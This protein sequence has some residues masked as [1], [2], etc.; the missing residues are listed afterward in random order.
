MEVLRIKPLHGADGYLRWKESVLLGLNIAGVAHVLSDDPPP[1]S[2]ARGVDG[3][4]A[5]LAS[6]AAAKKQWARD[7]AVC[8]GHI[9]RALS[10]RLLPV[11][12]RHGTGRA[13]W[14]AVARTYEPNP[15]SWALKLEEL[16]FGKDETLLERL[17]RAEALV[18]AGSR[19]RPGP[20][21]DEC[22]LARMVALKLQGELAS[23]AI[24]KGDRLTMD[25]VWRECQANEACT[26]ALRIHEINKRQRRA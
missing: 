9:L 7:D 24:R 17:A 16:E 4:A 3:G 5:E 10:D 23:G 8:R 2:P 20:P 25:W 6:A 14:E 13:V 19:R 21:P 18:I 15:H 22:T 12:I 11:Y 1:P 26:S